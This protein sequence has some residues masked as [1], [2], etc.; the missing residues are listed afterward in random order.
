[1]RLKF[2]A[3]TLAAAM[4]ATAMLAGMALASSQFKQSAKVVLTAKKEGASTGFNASLQSSDPGAPLE[5]PQGLKTLTVTFPSKT[6][7]NFKSKALALCNAND[8]EMVAT[9]GSACPAKSKLG[10]GSASANG[11][12]ALPNIQENVTAYATS[13]QVVLLLAPKVLGAGSVIVLH[14]K[15]SANKMTTEVPPL[16]VGGLTIVITGLQ[17]KVKAVGSGKTTWAKAGKCVSK[18][19]TV[20]SEFLYE[21]GEKLT[22]SSSSGCS[23]K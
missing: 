3:T 1:M 17:L 14:G 15:I 13:G 7:F 18:K 12:P 2:T 23:R 10:S 6:T 20:K 4:L 22:I 8:T 16:K 21:T 19:F 5:K 11:A 9:G